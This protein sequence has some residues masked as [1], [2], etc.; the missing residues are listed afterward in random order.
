MNKLIFAFIFFSCCF[1]SCVDKE[2]VYQDDHIIEVIEDNNPPPYSGVTTVEL[3]NYVN[4]TYID[5]IGRE[6][7]E[8]ELSTTTDMLRQANISDASVEQFLDALLVSDAY[9]VRFNDIYFGSMLNSTDDISIFYMIEF[10]NNQLTSLTDPLEIQYVEVQR[11]K[12]IALQNAKDD[13][14]NNL[15]NINEYMSRIVYNFFYDEINMGT[16]NFVLACFENF[17]KRLPTEI[18]LENSKT[19]VNGF[20]SQLLL[21]DG[22]TKER[23]IEIMTTND[24]FYQG[25]GIDVYIQL[26]ARNPDS[27]EMGEAMNNLNQG[28]W[29][30]QDLQKEIIK[31]EEYRGF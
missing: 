18:E 30:Y 25:L 21:L 7:S 3:N 20:P 1:Y 15:I 11:D 12:L 22:A 4:K 19:M 29:T 10:F 24:E 5:L 13:Y 9:Y 27:P 14:Q 28:I 2:T 23:F 6:P 16:E 8:S 26:L 31:S 17:F